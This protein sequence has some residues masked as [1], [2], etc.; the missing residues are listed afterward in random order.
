MILRMQRV[1]AIVCHIAMCELPSFSF[2]SASHLCSSCAE[3]DTDFIP[4]VFSRLDSHIMLGHCEGC[5][6]PRDDYAQLHMEDPDDS[7]F[8]Q[9]QA[10]FCIQRGWHLFR[11]VKLDSDMEKEERVQIGVKSVLESQIQQG[12]DVALICGMLP[13]FEQRLASLHADRDALRRRCSYY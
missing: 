1:S 5:G 2:C 6:M 8:L 3:G 10:A 13:K 4:E 9:A 12:V 7:D 11:L